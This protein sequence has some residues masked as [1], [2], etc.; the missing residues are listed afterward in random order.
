MVAGRW[1]TLFSSEASHDLHFS[2]E[3]TGNSISF[4]LLELANRPEIQDKVRREIR[5]A[6]Q[7]IR[8]RGDAQFDASDY[9]RMVY[10]TAVIK[11]SQNEYN[12]RIMPTPVVRKFYG[13]ILSCTVRFYSQHMTMLYHCQSL[14]AMSTAT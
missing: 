7:S 13:F 3:T 14:S 12:H 1:Y 11:V 8:T 6:L 10:T 5:T 2:D 9:D 4:L